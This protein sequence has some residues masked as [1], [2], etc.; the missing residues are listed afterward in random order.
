ML[1]VSSNLARPMVKV[2]FIASALLSVVSYYTTQQ[3]MVLYLSTWFSILAALG[4][5]SALLM[6]AWMI[7]V[8]RTHRALLIAVYAIT[9]VVSIAFSY[10]SLHTWFT[11]RERPAEMRRKLYDELTV[12]AA[13]TEETLAGATAEGRKHALA[14][15]EMTAAEKSHGRIS[16]SRDAD[17]YLDQVREAVGREARSYSEGYREGSGSGVRYTAFERYTRLAQQSL[18]EIEESRRAL[19]AFRAELTPDTPTERQLRRFHAVYDS[20]PWATVEQ[21]LHQGRIARPA[22]P[23]YATY[24]EQ[25]STGQES[26]MRAFE[27]LFTAP[28]GRHLFAFLLA[29]FIDII[30]FLLAYASGP[31][32]FGTPEQRWCSA[33]AAL[34]SGEPQ[35]FVRDLLRKMR[36]GPKGMAEVDARSLTS[37]EQQLCMVLA[38]RGLA[39]VEERDGR[40]CYRF[41]P[42]IHERLMESLATPGLA[43]RASAQGAAA[44]A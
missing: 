38:A 22:A 17:P 16:R 21:T 20:T 6:V 29:A 33:G 1:D 31:Y 35:L 44:G 13:R 41:D 36:P 4:V 15:E 42:Q 3:G 5:Q 9:A 23:D 32:F 8:T 40:L 27:E 28:T 12:M 7:G 37:G 24:L 43:V 34:D 11:A 26:L 10:V 30:V 18:T 39:L 25:A 2:L 19:A 14:L